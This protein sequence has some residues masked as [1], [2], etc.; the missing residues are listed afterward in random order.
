MVF[1]WDRNTEVKSGELVHGIKWSQ[2][3]DPWRQKPVQHLLMEHRTEANTFLEK[4]NY[5][6]DEE[7]QN[8]NSQAAMFD[9]GLHQI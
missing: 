9:W 3:S 4:L 8:T 1:L 2:H 6:T 7:L 5:E